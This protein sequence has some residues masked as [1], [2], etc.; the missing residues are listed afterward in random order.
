MQKANHKPIPKNHKE[1]WL[2]GGAY[3]L[4]KDP[5]NYLFVNMAKNDGIF[6]IT[7]PVIKTVVIY[8]PEHIKYVLQDNN[9]NY[10]KSRAYKVLAGL[11]GQGL[12]TS[13]GDFWRK[14]RRMAQPAFHKERLNAMLE[15]MVTCTQET[16]ADLNTVKPAETTNIANH[17]M[18]L[19][20]NIVAKAM[21]GSEIPDNIVE[22]VG[23]ELNIANELALERVSSPVKLPLWV[24][25]HKNTE[26]LRAC[27]ALYKVIDDIIE[28][29][30]KT[31]GHYDDLLQMLMEAKDEDTGEQMTD[32]Q[33]RDECL[34][35]FLAGHETTALALSWLWKLLSDNPDKKATLAAE[36]EQVLGNR[37][38]TLEDLRQLTYTRMC[39]DEAMRLYPPAWAIGRRAIEADVIGGHFIAPNTNVILPVYCIHRS[40]ELWD[41]PNDF[42]P[43]RF[44]KER[45][46]GADKFAYFPFGGGPRLCIGNNF[47]LMEMQIIVA[48][49][50]QH[51]NF[52]LREGQTIETD[53]LLTLRPK[54]GNMP[55]LVERK[56]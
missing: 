46:K 1:H 11:L 2:L 3:Y 26:Q 22:T 9:K 35:I 50:V 55:M 28:K 18:A 44:D 38:P 19:T 7:S 39:I 24:P 52:N 5:V 15:T 37:T 4:I 32:K 6:R 49:L 8:N 43:E 54:D 27:G 16:I 45:I 41:K 14:Q 56:G 51:F 10:T 31:S 25:T 42:I 17:M 33:L 13:E 53:I 34:T 12:L 48:M 40:P 29:R 20:L 23:R 30:H 21:F 36:V 47:A